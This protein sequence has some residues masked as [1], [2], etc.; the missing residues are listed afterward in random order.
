M[1]R[2]SPYL[3][4][5]E[6]GRLAT[7]E[8]NAA[9]RQRFHSLRCRGLSVAAALE[10]LEADPDGPGYGLA[11]ESLRSIVYC[12]SSV[13]PWLRVSPTWSLRRLG[14]LVGRR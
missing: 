9:I 14:E 7:I 3:S 6:R 4:D 8:R 1:T 5:A 12:T 13:R 11:F 2:N 10:G